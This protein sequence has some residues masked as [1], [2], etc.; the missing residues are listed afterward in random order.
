MMS[1]WT[2]EKQAAMKTCFGYSAL[3]VLDLKRGKLS[4]NSNVFS[5]GAVSYFMLMGKHLFFNPGERR[6]FFLGAYPE[7]D[8]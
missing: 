8:F 4:A 1:E 3:E 6:R 2:E 5:I 7:V